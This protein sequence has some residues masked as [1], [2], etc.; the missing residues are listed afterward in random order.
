MG[1][2][3]MLM[4]LGTAGFVLALGFITPAPA[5]VRRRSRRG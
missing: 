2:S 4:L 5:R 3:L 1:F